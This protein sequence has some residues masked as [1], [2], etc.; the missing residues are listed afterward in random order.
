MK[1]KLLAIVAAAAIVTGCTATGGGSSADS[2]LQADNSA[3]EM[4]EMARKVE[5][6]ATLSASDAT[7][8]TLRTNYMAAASKLGTDASG[9]P[10]A[11]LS[12]F[13][14]STNR[15]GGSLGRIG[16]RTGVGTSGISKGLGVMNDATAI[17]GEVGALA[18]M[19]GGLGG[20]PEKK[21]AKLDKDAMAAA[22]KAGCP[23]AT[24]G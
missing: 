7:C 21:A 4:A 12:T 23:M 16:Y 24:F 15:V 10:L 1:T 22:L 13:N 18:S 8:Q 14:R 20:S 9:N 3:N 19:F 2:L 11:Q 17:A 5:A 6:G